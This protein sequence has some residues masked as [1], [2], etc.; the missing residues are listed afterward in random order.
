[1]KV[2]CKI[3]EDYI[4]NDNGYSVESVKATCQRCGHIV[5][6]RGRTDRSRKWC[7]FQMWQ[8]CSKGESNFYV[9]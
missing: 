8:E 2:Q 4:E 6:C 5:E 1:M 7:L 9:D 3:E